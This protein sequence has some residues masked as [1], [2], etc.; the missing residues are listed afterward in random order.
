[1]EKTVPRTKCK[2]VPD[3]RC[4]DFPINIPRKECK[5]F[6]KTVCT[7]DPVNVKKKIP[8]KTCVLI[9]REV[10]NKVPRQITKEVPKTVGKKV[11]SSTKPSSSYGHSGSSYGG[12]SY[13]PPYLVDCGLLQQHF[14]SFLTHGNRVSCDSLMSLRSRSVCC[15]LT[16]YRSRRRRGRALQLSW[17]HV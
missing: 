15:N 4:Q 3:K 11:C 1:M 13:L 6:P 12:P 7:Q 5:E 2:Q 9:P 10:C 17:C 8:K 14:Y 16:A